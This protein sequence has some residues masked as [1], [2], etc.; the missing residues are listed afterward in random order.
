MWLEFGPLNSFIHRNLPQSIENVLEI[1]PQ[2]PDTFCNYY[3]FQSISISRHS[4]FLM[5]L[6]YTEYHFYSEL[7]I[8][9]KGLNLSHKRRRYSG[10]LSLP[11]WQIDSPKKIYIL[12]G[13]QICICRCRCYPRCNCRRRESLRIFRNQHPVRTSPAFVGLSIIFDKY[14]WY[15]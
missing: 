4:C 10:L 2:T 12:I 15:T 13:P 9:R 6:P 11:T 14:R 8:L 1:I 5:L 7:S 3:F